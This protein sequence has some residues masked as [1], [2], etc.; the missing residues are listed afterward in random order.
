MGAAGKVLRKH[1]GNS[2]AAY[3]T[4]RPVWG[5]GPGATPRPTPRGLATTRG[6]PV[7]LYEGIFQIAGGEMMR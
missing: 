3:P 2:P 1:R 7:L 6:H 5:W 4:V